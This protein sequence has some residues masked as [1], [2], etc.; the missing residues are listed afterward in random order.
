MEFACIHLI[1]S[2]TFTS[3]SPVQIGECTG[4]TFY[5]IIYISSSQ[6]IEFFIFYFLSFYFLRFC[7]IKQLDMLSAWLIRPWLFVHFYWQLRRQQ[8][9]RLRSI[10]QSLESLIIADSL[11]CFDRLFL[12]HLHPHHKDENYFLPDQCL[13]LLLF[14]FAL[15]YFMVCLPFDVCLYLHHGSFEAVMGEVNHSISSDFFN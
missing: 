6:F 7:Q 8:Q 2:A 14:F 11:H 13:I 4:A 3:P 10:N 12:I 1:S 15:L 5:A 9:A